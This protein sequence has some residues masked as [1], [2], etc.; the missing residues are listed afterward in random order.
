M[1]GTVKEI[2][3]DISVGDCVN[4]GEELVIIE[5][6][7]ME[8]PVESPHGRGPGGRYRV[9]PPAQIEEG[10]LLPPARSSACTLLAPF[11]LPAHPPAGL[12]NLADSAASVRALIIIDEAPRYSAPAGYIGS[13]LKLRLAGCGPHGA[14]CCAT[15]RGADG[16][17]LGRRRV[18][19]RARIPI[20]LLMD[21]GVKDIRKDRSS[22]PPLHRSMAGGAPDPSSAT[23]TCG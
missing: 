1:T 7:K 3:V 12:A 20:R 14:G 8:I 21:T 9:Y 11:R 10:A 23:R 15:G 5:S 17:G 4:M 18:R 22:T 2:I 6:M 16:P 13:N 19:R